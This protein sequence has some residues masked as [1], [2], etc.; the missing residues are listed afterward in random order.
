MDTQK[1]IDASAAIS[2]AAQEELDRLGREIES[3]DQPEPAPK[4]RHD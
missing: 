4:D 2:Q 1:F 3:L